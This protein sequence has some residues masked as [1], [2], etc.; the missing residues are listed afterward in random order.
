MIFNFLHHKAYWSKGRSKAAVERSIQHS[1]CFGVYLDGQQL[2]F[3]RVVTDRAIFA[4]LMDVFILPEFRGLGAGKQLLQTIF[5][6]PELKTVK[7]WG[8]KTYDTHSLYKQF[9][10]QPLS[11]PEVFMERSSDQQV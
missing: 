1:I 5:D 7:T 6:H 11:R 10:F 2:G 8:L 3:A 4:W 9:D